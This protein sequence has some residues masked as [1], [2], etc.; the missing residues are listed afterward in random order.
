MPAQLSNGAVRRAVLPVAPHKVE[1]P[2]STLVFL[3]IEID[4]A[5]G[6]LRLPAV[7]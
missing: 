6:V 7:K 4:T 5:S 1:G 3:G 2:S